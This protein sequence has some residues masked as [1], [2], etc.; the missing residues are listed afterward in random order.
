MVGFKKENN[1]NITEVIRSIMLYRITIITAV[2]IF[3]HFNGMGYLWL[4]LLLFTSFSYD[5]DK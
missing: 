5:S 4:L 1:E 2:L 3:A